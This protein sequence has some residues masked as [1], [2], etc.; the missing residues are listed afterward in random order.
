M[1]FLK[2]RFALKCREVRVLDDFCRQL[3]LSKAIS[4]QMALLAPIL[5]PN[6]SRRL[7]SELKPNLGYARSRSDQA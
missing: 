3:F 2:W 5:A 6:G 4:I 7:K 1:G